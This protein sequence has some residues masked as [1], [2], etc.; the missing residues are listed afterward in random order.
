VARIS[1]RK[2]RA[3]ADW[4][5]AYAST[6]NTF[7]PSIHSSMRP[8]LTK[9]QNRHDRHDRDELGYRETVTLAH[10]ENRS[11]KISLAV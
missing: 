2:T 3:T 8:R 7:S 11:R 6:D 5:S 4:P 9:N 10:P 1:P